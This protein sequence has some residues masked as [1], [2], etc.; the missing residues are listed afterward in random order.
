M[1]ATLER[2]R[3][4]GDAG[5]IDATKRS[6]PDAAPEPERG[7]PPV[8]QAL[9]VAFAGGGT[10]GHIVPGRHLLA[11]GGVDLADVLWFCTGRPVEARA[12]GGL[13]VELGRTP[14]ARVA[15]ALEPDGGGAPTL[16]RLAFRLAPAVLRARR[17]LREHRSEVLLGLGGF[18]TLPAVLAARSLGLP[19]AQLE[20]NASRGRATRALSPLAARVFHA[21][22]TTLPSGGETSRDLWTGPPLAPAFAGAAVTPESSERARASIGFR[23]DRP[24]LVVL[25]GS[26][27][28]ESLNRFVASEIDVFLRQGLQVLHQTGPGRL[29]QGASERAGYRKLEFVD[30]VQSALA[31]ATVVLCR[32]G[33][34]TLAEVAAMRRPAFVVPYPHHADRHQERNARELGAG[35]QIVDQSRLGTSVAHEL[36]LLTTPAGRAELARRAHELERALP[37]DAAERIWGELS[38]LIAARRAIS[39]AR[40]RVTQPDR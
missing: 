27:G 33:A 7:R 14:L 34:S 21:W 15:L 38:R 19:V 24:L 22:R 2:P 20:I 10:G 23:P 9:R 4:A 35:A 31:A 5:A 26:Q 18:T 29:E 16:K 25:G 39:S 12:F 11:R 32:G 36:V 17:E 13:D 30:D 37:L 40:T 28:A 1:R 8:L 6:R 3:G